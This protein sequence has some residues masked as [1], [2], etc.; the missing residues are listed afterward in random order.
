MVAEIGEIEMACMAVGPGDVHALAGG[1][2]HLDVNRFFSRFER[3]GHWN[4]SFAEIV[5]ICWSRP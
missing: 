3:D 1:Y 5:T 2:T 4:Q